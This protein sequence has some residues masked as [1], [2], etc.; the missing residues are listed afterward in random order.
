MKNISINVDLSGCVEKMRTEAAN[1][2]ARAE[3]MGLKGIFDVMPVMD[4]EVTMISEWLSHSML[5]MKMLMGRKLVSSNQ[6]GNSMVIVVEVPDN[7]NEVPA[8]MF[9]GYAK[10]FVVAELMLH[11]CR[12]CEA[13]S[14]LA[15]SVS[16]LSK[17]WAG[18][19]DANW[20][21]MKSVLNKRKR[22]SRN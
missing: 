1:T 15:G 16:R 18:V 9:G 5:D 11:W 3:L 10:D 20:E 2:A 6:S 19:R 14:T 4:E 13:A 7:F 21:L 22:V 17:E 12:W 8:S